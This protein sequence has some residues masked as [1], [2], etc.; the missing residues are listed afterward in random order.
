MRRLFV[1]L[2]ICAGMTMLAGVPVDR[3]RVVKSAQIERPS[4]QRAPVLA[5]GNVGGA[6]ICLL[7]LWDWNEDAMGHVTVTA[8]DPF[9]CGGWST[10]ISA[11]AGAGGNSSVSGAAPP[12][13]QGGQSGG[14]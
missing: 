7:H 2:C 5:A 8:N 11:G 9:Y 3:S 1:L 12:G 13:S 10:T 4:I 6:R 14:L